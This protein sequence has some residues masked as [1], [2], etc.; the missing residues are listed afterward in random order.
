MGTDTHNPRDTRSA[1]ERAGERPN[2]KPKRRR[3]QNNALKRSGRRRGCIFNFKLFSLL[4]SDFFFI[5][6]E[7][8]GGWWEGGRDVVMNLCVAIFNFLFI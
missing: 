2:P 5:I 6:K 3:C 1:H 4:R 8:E 7:R